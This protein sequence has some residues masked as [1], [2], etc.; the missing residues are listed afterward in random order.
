MSTKTAGICAS[1][2]RNPVYRGP[3]SNPYSNPYSASYP[4]A[5]PPLSAPNYPT[6]SRPLYA[7]LDTRWMKATSVWV[8]SPKASRLLYAGKATFLSSKSSPVVSRK[9]LCLCHVHLCIHLSI[10]SIIYVFIIYLCLQL[11]LTSIYLKTKLSVFLFNNKYTWSNILS[12]S[13]REGSKD[14]KRTSFLEP[15]ASH[16]LEWNVCS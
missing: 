12:E 8:S 13:Q 4:A 11:Y 15:S 7:A 10:L 5:A 1:P 16:T 9:P 2:E 6:I 3:Y 14:L